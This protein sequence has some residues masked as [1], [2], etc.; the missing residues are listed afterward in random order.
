[1]ESQHNS[2]SSASRYSTYHGVKAD[3]VYRCETC[4][5]TFS[6]R[7]NLRIHEKHV[8]S[9]ERLFTCEICAKTF[10][11]KKDVVRHHKQVRTDSVANG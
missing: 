4:L 3:L 7:S 5:K 1:M 10:K 8:H 2:L 6:N 9:S 11:R